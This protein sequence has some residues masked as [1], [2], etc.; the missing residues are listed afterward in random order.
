M[1]RTRLPVRARSATYARLRPRHLWLAG[2]HNVRPTT[3][4]IAH[5]LQLL[6]STPDAPPPADAAGPQLACTSRYAISQLRLT[7]TAGQ[8][9]NRRARFEDQA[10]S[11]LQALRGISMTLLLRASSIIERTTF[12]SPRSSPSCCSSSR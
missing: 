6:S 8:R 10:A 4:A 9:E 12:S 11:C 7:S 3:T 1:D 2:A 5:F